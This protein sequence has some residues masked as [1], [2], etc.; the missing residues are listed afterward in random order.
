MLLNEED[1]QEKC[2][3]PEDKKELE[4]FKTLADFKGINYTPGYDIKK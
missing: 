1:M 4:D 3:I 2:V